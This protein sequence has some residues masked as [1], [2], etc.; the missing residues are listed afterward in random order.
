MLTDST[1]KKPLT[2][3]WS[4]TCGPCR[5]MKPEL[6]ALCADADVEL[7]EKNIADCMDEVRKLGIRGVPTVALGDEILFV[8]GF[9]RASM[10][11]MLKAAGVFA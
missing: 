3:Y 4:A 1:P 11:T 7:I 8:G 2:I 9:S 5:S 10:E 6:R